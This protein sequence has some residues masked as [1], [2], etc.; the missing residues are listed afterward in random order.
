MIGKGLWSKADVLRFAASEGPSI[1]AIS[2]TGNTSV[3]VEAIDNVS[4]DATFIKLDVEG[5]ELEALK[6][7]AGTIR[8]NRPKLAICMYHKPGDLF[9]IPLFIKSLAPEYR[10]YLRQHQPVSCELVLYAVI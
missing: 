4:P 7:A 3:E 1:S 5:A 8:R 6:G 2:G 9:E 10:F